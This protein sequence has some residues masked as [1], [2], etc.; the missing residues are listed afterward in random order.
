MSE[1]APRINRMTSRYSPEEDRLCLLSEYAD[2][3]LGENNSA[4]LWLSQRLLLRLVPV[5]IECLQLGAKSLYAGVQDFAQQKAC[6]EQVYEPAVVEKQTSLSWLVKEVDIQH[7]ENSV[8]LVFKGTQGES[9]Q[10]IL[11]EVQLRQWLAILYGQFCCAEWPRD[12]W[13][14]WIEP[15]L[16]EA[17]TAMK[18]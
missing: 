17:V 5:L 3:D 13:P 6:A 18:H 15:E 12:T 9:A 11:S 14:K 2:P 10:L 4:T 16:T 8:G 7:G 1:L